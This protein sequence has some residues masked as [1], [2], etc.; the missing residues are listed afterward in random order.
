V[1]Y[2]QNARPL[3]T[4]SDDLLHYLHSVFALGK[5]PLFP[6]ALLANSLRRQPA[7][8]SRQAA[9]LTRP[10][11]TA[12]PTLREL[13]TTSGFI[14]QI[15]FLP[16]GRIQAIVYENDCY[17]LVRLGVGGRLDEMMLFNGRAGSRFALFGHFLAVNPPQR[18]QLLILDVRG[19]RPQ[20]MTL[21]ETAVFQDTAVFAA[22]PD[23]LYRIAGSWV[24]RGSVQ[25]GHYVE[26]MIGS[27]HKNQTWFQASPYSDT[28]AGVHRIFAE[29][30]HFVQS[31]RGT[32]DL[33]LP[34][35]AAQ[36]FITGSRFAFGRD[37]VALGVR[38]KGNGR[39]S[40]HLHTFDHSGRL[41]ST[42]EVEEE[43]FA[44]RISNYPITQL[45]AGVSETAVS[46]PH[47]AGL[48]I[49]E[50]SRLLLA[51]QSRN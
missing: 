13:Y 32:F 30:H 16:H 35:L 18:Q 51:E 17:K 15:G 50:P 19:S 23:H 26:E 8:Y 20:Q 37:T 14:E 43:G 1:T 34:P 36:E 12:D 9:A 42:Q 39:L 33:R 5:R 7:T 31:S 40:H 45:P 3:D 46:H 29:N 6:P 22:T 24:M 44:R 47:P 4:L 38:L 25:Q 48:L 10:L 27:T 2:P 11:A 49:Q 21:I 41:I 28:I